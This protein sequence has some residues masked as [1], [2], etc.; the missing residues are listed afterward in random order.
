MLVRF[1]KARAIISLVAVA[2]FLLASVFISR[3]LFLKTNECTCIQTTQSALPCGS[4]TDVNNPKKKVLIL[5]AYFEKDAR[6]IKTLQYFIAL[7]VEESDT[8]DYLFI[9][10]GKETSVNIPTYKN[11]RVLKRE[12]TCYDFGAYGAG[13]VSLGGLISLTNY[14]YFV[15]INPSVMGPVMPKFWP[16]HLHWSEIFTSR[17]KGDVHAVGTSIVCEYMGPSKLHIIEAFLINK[18]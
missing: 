10:Q 2:A 11:V 18:V 9:I 14:S 12:N 17:L 3:K 13:L 7:G 1:F 4:A 15:F 5:Y 16:S 6:Y 8:I